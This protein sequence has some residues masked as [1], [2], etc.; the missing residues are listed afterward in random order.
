VGGV[1]VANLTRMLQGG[2]TES[3]VFAQR[4]EGEETASLSV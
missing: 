1:G 2:L 3:M 4:S